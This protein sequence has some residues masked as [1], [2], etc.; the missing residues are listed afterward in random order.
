ML[1]PDGPVVWLEKSARGFFD[2]QGKL[3][4]MIGMVANITERK[5]AEAA[6]AS[7]SCRLIEAQEQEGH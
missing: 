6:F 1:R 3:L 2:E 7:V 4:R 5:P